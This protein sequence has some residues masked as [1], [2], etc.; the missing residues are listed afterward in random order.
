MNIVDPSSVKNKI[1]KKEKPTG[2]V[3]LKK[4][5]AKKTKPKDIEGNGESSPDRC[6]YASVLHFSKTII[7]QVQRQVALLGVLLQILP[8]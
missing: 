5:I 1:P 6:T 7:I 4:S 3:K 2:G 8:P